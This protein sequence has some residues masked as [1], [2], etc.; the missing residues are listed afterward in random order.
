MNIGK[1]KSQIVS[2][3]FSLTL[4]IT[5][6]FPNLAN[7]ESTTKQVTYLAL[8]DSLAAGQNPYMRLGKGYTDMLA[9]DLKKIGFLN[10][11]SK[12][13]AISGYTSQRVLEDILN[14]VKKG[15]GDTIGIRGN[16]A[17][18]D[19]ITLDAGANDLLRKMKRTDEGLSIDPD[20]LAQV[21]TQVES[22]IEYILE[23]IHTL[24]PEAKVYVMGYYNAYPYLPTEQQEQ[25]LPI[26]NQLN[27][28]IQD[29]AN[30]EATVYVPT[31][32]SIAVNPKAYLPNSKDIH[33]G[34]SGYKTITAEFWKVVY[35][36]VTNNYK[37]SIFVNGIYQTFEQDPV[38][39]KGRTLVHVRGVFDDLGAEVSWD[40]KTRSVIIKKGNDVIKLMVD[41][42]KVYK[43]GKLLQIDVSAK[44]IND[45]TMIP[46][47]F[48]SESFG[49]TVEWEPVT[50][51]AFIAN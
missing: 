8:G 28:A 10:S 22:N 29:A 35:P 47:R 6:I 30:R 5:L 42:N 4:V 48:I 13:Y 32:D 3:F 20:V 40:N 37:N 27:T 21:L 49:A 51:N 26:L 44:I 24:N 33:P 23:E 43:N 17:K 50:R 12:L 9:E 41:S 36:D 46:L 45:R 39:I 14:D 1:K 38:I 7:A 19:V 25:F 11:F 2:L 31:K 15:T 18:A 16:I 34:L